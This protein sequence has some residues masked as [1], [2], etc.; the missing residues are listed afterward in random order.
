MPARVNIPPGTRFGKLVTIEQCGHYFTPKGLKN[1]P[2]YRCKCDCGETVIVRASFLRSS[3]KRVSRRCC[4]CTRKTTAKPPPVVDREDVIYMAG[5]FD[6]EGCIAIGNSNHSFHRG[7][8]HFY[9][10]LG[11]SSTNLAVLQWVKS[12]FGGCLSARKCGQLNRKH[13]WTWYASTRHAFLI[14]EIIYP[15]LKVKKAEAEIGL[16]F[17]RRTGHPDATEP[18]TGRK[19]GRGLTA[20]EIKLRES[21]RTQLKDLKRKPYTT[22]GESPIERP[23]IE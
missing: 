22:Y 7:R 16:Q 21:L 5:F 12:R 23:G 19:G 20:A 9:L 6:G 8:G 1:T 17:G 4:G 2:L 13:A 15:F 3:D 11:M 14:L 10:T 18:P